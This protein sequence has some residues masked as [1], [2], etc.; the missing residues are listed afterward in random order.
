MKPKILILILALALGLVGCGDGGSISPT[1]TE[2]SLDQAEVA[3]N[4]AQEEAAQAA[5]EEA[6]AQAAATQ[7]AADPFPYT[8]VLSCGINGFDNIN[9]MACMGGDVETE[10]ELNNNGNYGLYKVYNIPNDWRQTERGVE[11]A[12]ANTFS[13]E[14]QN[15]SDSLIM[16]LIPSPID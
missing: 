7:A 11:I 15:S 6:A 14:M 12:L 10:I 2:N 1:T 13:L 8:A 3:A 9:L 4:A 16:G 5:A